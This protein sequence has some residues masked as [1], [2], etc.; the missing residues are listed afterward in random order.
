MPVRRPNI[1]WLA[2]GVSLLNLAL[3]F[4]SSFQSQ[5]SDIKNCSIVNIGHF[6]N[7]TIRC[8]LVI[9]ERIVVVELP[10]AN[11]DGVSTLP[12][13][14]ASPTLTSTPSPTTSATVV[15][16]L[17][18]TAKPTSTLTSATPTA[19]PITQSR[20]ATPSSLLPTQSPSTTS[21]PT[22]PA[23]QES[24]T[25]PVSTPSSRLPATPA[26]AITPLLPVDT[27]ITVLVPTLTPELTPILQIETATIAIVTP[28]A[29]EIAF[30]T[31]TPS[32]TEPT[33][34]ATAT[35]SQT[36]TSTATAIASAT[37]TPSQIV[38]STATAT[39]SAT[40]TP[41]ATASA[42]PSPT[43]TALILAC[44]DGVPPL[45]AFAGTVQRYGGPTTAS[46]QFIAAVSTE[47]ELRLKV[48]E[49]HPDACLSGGKNCGQRQRAESFAVFFNGV[50]VDAYQDRGP[51]DKV[52]LAGPWRVPFVVNSG[53]HQIDVQHAMT[54]DDI[55]S[56]SFEIIACALPLP[57]VVELPTVTS[58]TSATADV[59]TATT[60]AVPTLEPIDTT[61]TEIPTSDPTPPAVPT[62]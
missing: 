45:T 55:G 37:A 6:N 33:A 39:P 3:W 54:G 24:P 21:Q 15:S 5:V 10:V 46:H 42:T 41:T 27:P 40:R 38:T 32:P 19:T 36:A 60:T 16:Q 17:L 58:T 14:S 59:P 47:A 29:T 43:P 8:E 9:E 11:S 56:V 44:S 53:E 1:A 57:A 20:T 26:P 4:T 31:E 34:S 18:S 61:A 22:V 7:A 50:E 35:P 62:P 2:L 51:E 25:V 49:G 52:H 13:P 28:L 30:P 12:T 23:P 48:T